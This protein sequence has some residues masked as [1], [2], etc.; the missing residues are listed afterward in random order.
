MT[1]AD[2]FREGAKLLRAAE[3]D[4]RIL[5]NVAWPSS[6]KLR[7]FAE[8]ARELPV[9]QYE[10]FDPAGVHA[11][12]TA[13]RVHFAGDTPIDA[14]LSRSAAAIGSSA[15]LLAAVGTPEFLEHSAT[16][17]GL[18]A[19][20]HGGA[21]P[22]ELA[23]TFD[24]LCRELS[25]IDLGAPAPACHLA[26]G[27]AQRMTA[28]CQERFGEHAP[29]VHMVEQLSAN[30]LAGP[31]RIQIRRDACFTDR[32]VDQLIQHEAFVHVCTS[33]NGRAQADL[34]ILAASHAGTT[35]TQEG[36]AVFAE[37]ITGSLEPDRLRR[38]ADRVLAIQMAIEGA[39]FLDIYRYFLERDAGEDQ[40]FESARRVYRGGVLTGGVPFTKDSVY[41]DGFL[42]VTNC[43]RSVVAQGRV[44]CLLLLFCGKL[45][46]EDLPALAQ[47]AEMGLCKA[48]RFLPPW[49]AD[50]RYL[51]TYLTYSSFLNGVSLAEHRAHYAKLLADAPVVRAFDRELPPGFAAPQYQDVTE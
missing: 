20:R 18:P 2:R 33:L 51:V 7:F 31:R 46:M 40:A 16:L 9:V 45:D 37:F 39:D 29:E 11:R 41:L 50:R 6:V 23:Q 12:L 42:R 43:L 30:A 21:S 26:H 38:L 17:Y 27:V 13:A 35:R 25:G 19:E 22:L 48:P 14:W 49:V 24:G 1:D 10:P 5:R 15:N 32:D 4:V 44:D 28:A 8:G 47:L 34:P 3:A 36:L